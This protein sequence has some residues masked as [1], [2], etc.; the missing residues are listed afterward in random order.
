[1]ECAAYGAGEGARA[2]SINLPCPP[3]HFLGTVASAVQ[4]LFFFLMGSISA[5]AMIKAPYPLGS[6]VT[7]FSL[8]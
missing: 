6:L 3:K 4:G 1:M 5:A 2:P 8:K 7:T